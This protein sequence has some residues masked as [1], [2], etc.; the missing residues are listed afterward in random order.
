MC[1]LILIIVIILIIISI[2]LLYYYSKQNNENFC[3]T[4]VG[5]IL[6]RYKFGDPFYKYQYDQRRKYERYPM[7]N[8]W[9]NLNESEREKEKLKVI[10]MIEKWI[11]VLGL[12]Q[13]G[14]P[15][16][17]KYIG[18]NP[19]INKI[20]GEKINKYTYII[21]KHPDKPWEKLISGVGKQSFSPEFL[22]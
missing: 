2:L 1:K 21:N 9:M 11:K 22:S 16:Y 7:I 12:N 4:C 10:Y 5:P 19:L 20:T 14:D 3:N 15:P 18:E 8:K 17:T 6:H 13:Y